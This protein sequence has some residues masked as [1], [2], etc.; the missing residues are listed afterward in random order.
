MFVIRPRRPTNIEFLEFE[1]ELKRRAFTEYNYTW[2]EGYEVD[3]NTSFI[4]LKM[5]V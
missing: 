2:K 4:V 1:E 3:R 5:F